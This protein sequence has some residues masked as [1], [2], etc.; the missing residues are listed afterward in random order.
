MD[1]SGRKWIKSMKVD[2]NIRGVSLPFSVSEPLNLRHQPADIA[3]TCLL[4]Q[5]TNTSIQYTP[6]RQYCHHR[7]ATWLLLRFSTWLLAFLISLSCSAVQD[8]QAV[9]VLGLE[10]NWT[11]EKEEVFER[12]YGCY[13]DK[14]FRNSDPP[15]PIQQI[16]EQSVQASLGSD[17]KVK[18]FQNKFANNITNIANKTNI[19]K[20][21]RFRH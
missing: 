11:L 13:F 10:G 14:Y 20:Y 4:H 17:E 7:F 15:I 8:C 16:V 9:S 18:K 2:E 3:T 6:T 19:A 1:E 12:F 21:F 5:Y